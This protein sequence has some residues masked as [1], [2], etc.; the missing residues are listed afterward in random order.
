MVAT[1]NEAFKGPSINSLSYTSSSMDSIKNGNNHGNDYSNDYSNTNTSIVNTQPS[2]NGN[3]N[4]N[5]N[6]Y[7]HPNIEG[8][9]LSN[10]ARY[11]KDDIDDI[12]NKYKIDVPNRYNEVSE[13]KCD[14]SI[15]HIL[16]CT[17]CRNKLKKLL[18]DDE[19]E[20]GFVADYPYQIKDRDTESIVEQC[21][22]NQSIITQS[23]SILDNLFEGKN[24]TG[25]VNTFIYGIILIMIM[26]FLIKVASKMIL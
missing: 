12:K 24:L 20:E 4:Y 26:N 2:R 9:P 11:P 1:L 25:L 23:K 10:P 3:S 13:N 14:S 6:N 5:S 17:K 15:Y 18:K 16:S 22:K 19:V 8:V 7:Q 21:N